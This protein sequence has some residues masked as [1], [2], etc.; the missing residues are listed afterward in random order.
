V[1]EFVYRV[2]ALDPG[3]TTGW[4]TYTTEA[5]GVKPYDR[6]DFTSGHLGPE[7][8]HQALE[9]LLGNQR[10]TYFTVVCERF[11]DRVGE[12]SIN[13]MA[14]EYIGVVERWC[15]ENETQLVM[16]TPAYAKGFI[17]D[18]NLKEAGLW[19]GPKWKHANDAKRHLLSYMINGTP[20]RHDWLRKI[21]K[22]PHGK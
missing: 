11:Q 20:H 16:Q 19:D 4:A 12:H 8:H 17:L 18:Y 14:R 7:K 2:L 1:S 6:L 10:T 13:L 15:Q 22:G 3:G 21:G 9:V 5:E